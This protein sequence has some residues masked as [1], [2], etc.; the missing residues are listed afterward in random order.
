MS[1]TVFFRIIHLKRIF[2]VINCPLYKNGYK[3]DGLVPLKYPEP[4]R[5]R[6]LELYEH[7]IIMSGP[8]RKMSH[9]KFQTNFFIHVF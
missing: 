1:P 2:L 5:I 9:E 7:L 6:Q 3:Y 8:F 4:L